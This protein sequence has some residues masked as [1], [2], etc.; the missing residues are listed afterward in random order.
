MRPDPSLRGSWYWSVDAHKRLQRRQLSSFV[1]RLADPYERGICAKLIVIL[2]PG[3]D[4]RKNVLWFYR[5][6]YHSPIERRRYTAKCPKGVLMSA[7]GTYHSSKCG[8]IGL[9]GSKNGSL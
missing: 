1:S 3:E 9:T 5:L 2:Y 4:G 6:A 8:C 7:T